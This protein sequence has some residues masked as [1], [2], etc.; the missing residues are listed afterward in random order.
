MCV[1]NLVVECTLQSVRRRIPVSDAHG[2]THSGIAPGNVHKANMSNGE[3]KEDRL[4]PARYL[5]SS[6]FVSGKSN[7]DRVQEL[8]KKAQEEAQLQRETTKAE[9]V[10]KTEDGNTEDENS[11]EKVDAVESSQSDE[12]TEVEENAES[13]KKDEIEG[14]VDSE[15]K[16]ES[17]GE[18]PAGEDA[19]VADGRGEG[20]SGKAEEPPELV[21]NTHEVL[22]E[23]IEDAPTKVEKPR[24]RRVA[25]LE[26]HKGDECSSE[27]SF[28]T[29]GFMSL[30][31]CLCFS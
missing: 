15:K 23:E 2:S 30:E 6:N 18:T 3:I 21:A 11:E 25:F 5:G 28:G 10:K 20:E 24:P 1:C 4:A 16:A 27:R 13:D 22:A 17:N 8:V 31:A 29:G 19:E 9:S 7:Q 26:S 14:G 12:K